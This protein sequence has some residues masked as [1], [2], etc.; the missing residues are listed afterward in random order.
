ME[1][2]SEVA[3]VCQQASGQHADAAHDQVL[4]LRQLAMVCR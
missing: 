2:A 4:L 1:L 3:E